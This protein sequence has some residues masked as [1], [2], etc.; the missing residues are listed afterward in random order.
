[1]QLA[2]LFQMRSM[3]EHPEKCLLPQDFETR[4]SQLQRNPASVFSSARTNSPKHKES[5]KAWGKTHGKNRHTCR[6]K[7][8][9]ELKI[10]IKG[11]RSSWSLFLWKCSQ[12]N[13]FSFT[14]TLC[15]GSLWKGRWSRNKNCHRKESVYTCFSLQKETCLVSWYKT[16]SS[17]RKPKT[18]P[19][20]EKKFSKTSWA[21][22]HDSWLAKRM[23][24]EK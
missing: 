23:N 20:I 16:K 18:P 13:P 21:H 7:Q 4:P 1:M 17:L 8:F 2:Y 14:Q 6:S 24:S 12:K 3:L 5:T 19:K 11:Y 15:V 22:S 10:E 9:M